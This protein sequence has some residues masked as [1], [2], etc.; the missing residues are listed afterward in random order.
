[1]GPRPDTSPLWAT[2]PKRI[3]RMRAGSVQGRLHTLWASLVFPQAPPSPGAS[4]QAPGALKS[5]PDILVILVFVVTLVFDTE[6]RWS[7]LE[8]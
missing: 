2:A 4:R 6:I 5:K 1:M 8:N 7:S 3:I